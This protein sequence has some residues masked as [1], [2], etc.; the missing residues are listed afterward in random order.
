MKKTEF[1]NIIVEIEDGILKIILNRPKQLNAL[2]PDLIDELWTTLNT[3]P[4]Y[5]TIRAVLITGNGKAFSAGGD[6]EL[7]LIPVSKMTP[8]E[9]RR[10][11]KKFC[12]VIQMVYHLEKPVIA[13]ING[14]TVGGG[15]DLAMACDIRIASTA[16]KFGHGYIKMGIISDMGG[17]YFLPRLIGAGKAKLFAFTGEIISA[18]E[19][20][21]I[22]LIDR[23]VPEGQFEEKV[24]E[25][26]KKIAFGPTEAIILAKEAMHRSSAMNL[27][28]SLEYSYNL[29][30]AL[31]DSEDFK[32]GFT[33]FIENR[34]PVF[35][36]K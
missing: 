11:I 8:M 19:A 18:E 5:P 23:L 7:D 25:L 32:E 31:L 15:C 22:G 1:K 9:W 20:E 29:Q 10:Y 24:A 13:A 33:A 34:K 27:E 36:G 14:V 2:S 6:I 35:K 16:A 17:H 21:H 12:A 3:I 4:E 30:S 28:E 26:T